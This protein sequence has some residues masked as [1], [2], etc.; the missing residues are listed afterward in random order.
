MPSEEVSPIVIPKF[1][2][3]AN[4]VT[5][6]R[7]GSVSLL[8]SPTFPLDICHQQFSACFCFFCVLQINQAILLLILA[9]FHQ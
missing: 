9:F 1:V 8:I 2:I 7:L 6:E 5:Y 4:W 3:L